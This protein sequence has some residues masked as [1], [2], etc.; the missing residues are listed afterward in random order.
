MTL[1]KVGPLREIGGGQ[2]PHTGKIPSRGI[3]NA[4]VPGIRNGG[5]GSS[6]DWT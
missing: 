1:A 4:P 2:Q 3:K 5:I 6:S